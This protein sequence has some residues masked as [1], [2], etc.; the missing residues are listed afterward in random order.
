M[1]VMGNGKAGRLSRLLFWIGIIYLVVPLLVAFY[2][3][4]LW[5]VERVKAGDALSVSLVSV[6]I[7]L[8][9][10]GVA[11]LREWPKGKDDDG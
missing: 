10:I 6:G 8:V 2:F 3:G 1:A 7:G 11:L 5:M 4:F 9:L